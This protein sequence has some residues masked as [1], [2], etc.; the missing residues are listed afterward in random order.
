MSS[1][2]NYLND[3]LK[4]LSESENVESMEV[5]TADDP[6]E[7]GASEIPAMGEESMPVE[8]AGQGPYPGDCTGG[9]L[10]LQDTQG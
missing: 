5:L 3:L 9:A 10:V 6:V 7:N 2:E 4:S 1:E 8:N